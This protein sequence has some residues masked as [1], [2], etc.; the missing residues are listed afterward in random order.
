MY[1]DYNENQLVNCV[2]CGEVFDDNDT[3]VCGREVIC[4][5][6]QIDNGGDYFPDDR[7]SPFDSHKDINIP[8]DIA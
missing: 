1:K 4:K 2:C 3:D 7:D 6:C 5:Q 8:L